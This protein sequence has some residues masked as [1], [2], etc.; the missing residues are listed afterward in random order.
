MTPKMNEESFYRH[1]YHALMQY[2]GASPA[3]AFHFAYAHLNDSYLQEWRF[4]GKLGFGGKYWRERNEI[5]CYKEDETPERLKI[6]EETNA[7]LK[8]IAN[9]HGKKF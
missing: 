9:Q 7:K 6:I 2:A 5:S 4:Q 3:E 8:E 1:I